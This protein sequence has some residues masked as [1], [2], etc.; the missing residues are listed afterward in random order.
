M[1]S[2]KKLIEIELGFHN[3]DEFLRDDSLPGL[4]M[5][6]FPSSVREK[7]TERGKFVAN[8]SVCCEIRFKTDAQNIKVFI[9]NETGNPLTWVYTG[10]IW[11]STIQLEEGKIN[12]ISLT[13]PDF[14]K[15]K[16]EYLY[17]GRFQPSV[18]RIIFSG[19]RNRFCG[20]ES[21]G[22][23]ISAAEENETPKIKWLAYGSS[24]THADLYG[25]APTAARLLGVDLFN[26][27]MSGSCFCEKETADFLATEID[28]DFATLELGVNMRN[29]IYPAEFAKRANYIVDK[30]IKEK[31]QKPIFLINTFPN[32]SDALTSPDKIAETQNQYR[33]ILRDIASGKKNQNV[34]LI[35]GDQILSDFTM[36]AP[37]LLHPTH[38]G[39][40]LMGFNLANIISKTIGK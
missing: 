17:N 25:Y 31:P 26:K 23:K 2:T 6:R 29:S 32:G 37:D 3:F 12:C 21:Y 9:Y 7:M 5:S 11:N 16:P 33:Q 40:S 24:I 15:Y 20:I 8:E 1:K 39:Q 35:E 14:S 36:L 4:A 34:H 18:W 27:G 10:D 38:P 19:G 30:F 13:K 22:H 28:W